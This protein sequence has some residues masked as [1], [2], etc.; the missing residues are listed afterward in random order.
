MSK[1]Q[2]D[3][4]KELITASLDFLHAGSN[5]SRDIPK[6]LCVGFIGFLKASL[7]KDLGIVIRLI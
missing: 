1:P 3:T 4:G 6:R 5:F 7:L 2:L